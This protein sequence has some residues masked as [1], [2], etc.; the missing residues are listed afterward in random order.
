MLFP[1]G[2]QTKVKPYFRLELRYL[3]MPGEAGSFLDIN[4]RKL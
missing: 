3:K 1:R 2:G 4:S